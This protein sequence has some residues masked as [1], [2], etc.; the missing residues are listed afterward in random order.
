[1]TTE[2]IWRGTVVEESLVD[3][4]IM[5]DFKIIETKTTDD[6]NPI[7]QWHIHTVISDEATIEKLSSALRERGW[8]AHFWN[9]NKEVIA[10]FPGRVFRFPSN[11]KSAWQPAIEYGLARGVPR[12]QLDFL[13]P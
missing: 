10:V 13:I 3:K 2:K 4:G 8:Y 5:R 12:P 9:K 11:D 1:M 6:D 7:E